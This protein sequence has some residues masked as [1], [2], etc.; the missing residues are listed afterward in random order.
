MLVEPTAQLGNWLTARA[1]QIDRA[2][3]K[4]RESV[5]DAVSA[6]EACS[7]IAAE[8]LGATTGIAGTETAILAGVGELILQVIAVTTAIAANATSITTTLVT[9]RDSIKDSMSNLPTIGGQRNIQAA[10]S[11]A[12]HQLDQLADTTSYIASGVEHLSTQLANIL[13][14]LSR[15]SDVPSLL[16]ALGLSMQ[17]I[18]RVLGTSERNNAAAYWLER[19]ARKLNIA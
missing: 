13:D 9:F 19:I 14:L 6:A 1:Q 5:R 18:E 3:E 11:S 12:N 8:I 4:L 16:R 2:Q 7:T 10:L 17:Q 15:L